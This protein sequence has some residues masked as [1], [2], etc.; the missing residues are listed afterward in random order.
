MFLLWIL[1]QICEIQLSLA[2]GQVNV[3]CV[4]TISNLYVY[5]LQAVVEIYL[6][7]LYFRLIFFFEIEVRINIVF[8]NKVPVNSCK[9]EIVEYSRSTWRGNIWT[10]IS[11]L[12]KTIELNWHFGVLESWSYCLWFS[13]T[14]CIDRTGLMLTV[15]SSF[16]FFVASILSRCF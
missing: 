2:R 11:Q 16:H 8:D 9:A 15:F 1:P 12:E 13:C 3:V 14:R 10:K 6:F 4:V 5:N 7:W